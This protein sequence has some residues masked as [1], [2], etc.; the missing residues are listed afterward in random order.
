[1][2]PAKIRDDV[3]TESDEYRKALIRVIFIVL[4]LGIVGGS[5]LGMKISGAEKAKE[6]KAEKQVTGD[7]DPTGSEAADRYRNTSPNRSR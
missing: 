1:M 4:G 7:N 6:A 5:C 3:D 2:E